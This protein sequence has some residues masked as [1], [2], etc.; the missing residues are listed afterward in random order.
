M[1]SFA[2]DSINPH[3]LSLSE[4]HVEEQDLLNLTLT[5]YSLGSS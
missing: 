3:I 2:L 1:N 5:D 4:H